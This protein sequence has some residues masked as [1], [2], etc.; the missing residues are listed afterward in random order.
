MKKFT[1]YLM[2]ILLVIFT[3]QSCDKNDD[4]GVMMTSAMNIVETAQSSSDLSNLVAALLKADESS[5]SDLIGTLSGSGPFTV[6]APTNEAFTSLLAGLDNYSSLDD[7]S[8]EEDKALLATILKYH[9]ISG[10]AVESSA[11]TNGQEISTV[12][13][14]MLTANVGTDI[15]FTDATGMSST[16]LSAD[17]EATNGIIHII[18][19]VLVPQEVL[20]IINLGTLV[21]VV[22]NT[23][24][25]SNL[26]AAVIKA[27]LV[28]T[29]NGDGPFT[30]FAPTD[31]AFIALMDAL[32]D[33]FNSL[34]DFDTTD[35]IALL[36]N[37]LLYH[38]IPAEVTSDMLSA[39]QV[40]TALTGNNIE[41]IASNSTFVI[42]DASDTD[43]NITGTDIM[44]SNG[45]AHTIDKV[46]LPQEAVD[47]VNSLRPNIVELAQDTADLS[48]LVAALAQA[49]AGLVDL[50]QTDGPFT[51]FAPTNQAFSDLL[52]DLGDDYNSLADFDTIEEKELLADILK[53][54]VVTVQALSTDLSDGQM[55]TTAQGED[56]T[57]S[58]TGGVFVQDATESD[59]EVTAPNIL[60]SNGVVHV[61]NKVLL[62][63]E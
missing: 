47:F 55:I 45:V 37:I 63:A 13:G 20:D 2:T 33:D 19:K 7:F 9:V 22:I 11:L 42:G 59:A 25:L 36:R 1:A 27:D 16:V 14:E 46:L 24:A 4:D 44:A 23:E 8:S 28:D 10:A 57:I 41:V 61:I 15:S 51:V 26:E 50:L 39:D 32:G 21:D 12:Q 31:D 54:H 56:I 60:A 29:L 43:A 52:D 40:P 53:Y 3:F 34:D 30:V 49:D 17:I 62:P 5:E 6:L 18:N 48:S 58:L 38:V 35:E